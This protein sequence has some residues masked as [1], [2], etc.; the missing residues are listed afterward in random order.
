MTNARSRESVIS[1]RDLYKSFGTLMFLQGIQS[2]TFIQLEWCTWPGPGLSGKSG[3][4]NKIISA[5]WAGWCKRAEV[6]KSF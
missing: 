2:L 1:I 6:A 5:T 3:V 4:L